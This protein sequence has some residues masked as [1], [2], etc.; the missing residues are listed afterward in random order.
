LPRGAT[1]KLDRILTKKLSLD[2]E[3]E[4]FNGSQ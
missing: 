2:N 3:W 4:K 1:D